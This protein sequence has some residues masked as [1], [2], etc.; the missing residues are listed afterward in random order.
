MWVDILDAAT[1]AAHPP[2]DIALPDP[3]PYVSS[4]LGELAAATAEA[5]AQAA[6]WGFVESKNDSRERP[7]NWNGV[8]VVCVP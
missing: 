2:L 6:E 3:A 8:G 5:E 4:C 7:K 1:A